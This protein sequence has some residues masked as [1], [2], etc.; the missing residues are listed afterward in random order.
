MN[1]NSWVITIINHIDNKFNFRIRQ[2]VEI[3][4]REDI[5][6]RD[7]QKKTFDDIYKK[8]VDNFLKALLWV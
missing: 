4:D 6:I 1:H 3:S 7:R 2:E 5:R 8:E